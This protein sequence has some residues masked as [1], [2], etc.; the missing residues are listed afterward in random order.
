MSQ[1]GDPIEIIVDSVEALVYLCKP[2]VNGVKALIYLI[3][4]LIDLIKALIYLIK[5]PIYL[6]KAPVYLRLEGYD[7]L[8]DCFDRGFGGHFFWH[9]FLR[10]PLSM[11][12]TNYPGSKKLIHLCAT[13]VNDT[14]RGECP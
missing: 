6:I 4:A 7:A 11:E 14:S 2:L 5:A 10:Q 3:K 13:T 1:A 12:R 8:E 9:F